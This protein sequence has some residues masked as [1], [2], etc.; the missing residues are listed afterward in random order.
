[1]IW[2]LLH[3]GDPADYAY[4][5]I[6]GVSAGAINTG[7]TALWETGQEKEMSEKLSDLWASIQDLDQI[8]TL[9]GNTI[10]KEIKGI[11]SEISALD[12]TPAF[13][14]LTESFKPYESI[15]RR[16]TTAAVDVQTGDY[17][18]MD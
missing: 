2:G 3:Y 15:K 5:V 16:F 10:A 4:D 17:V 9:R 8:F 14:F 1:M 11:L 13:E 6:T 7:F 12:D 18:T